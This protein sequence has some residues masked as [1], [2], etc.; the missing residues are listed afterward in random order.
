[1]W[2]PTEQPTLLS[3]SPPL[4][5]SVWMQQLKTKK[6]RE[7]KV[8]REERESVRGKT[9]RKRRMGKVKAAVFP[10]LHKWKK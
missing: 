5:F 3:S 6:M 2:E 8:N 4:L 1:V 10:D 7:R 9:R